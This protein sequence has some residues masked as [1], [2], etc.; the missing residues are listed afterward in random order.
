[1]TAKATKLTKQHIWL[2][3][4]SKM[5]VDLVEH[6]LSLDVEKAIANISELNPRLSTLKE[7]KQWFIQDD[8]QKKNPKYVLTNWLGVTIQPKRV[9]QDM[10]EGL[11]ET[12]REIDDDSSMQM[13]QSYGYA[14]NKLTIT[15]QMTSEI[16]SLNYG[17]ADSSGCALALQ[18]NQKDLK[19]YNYHEAQIEMLSTLSQKIFQELLNDNLLERA[20][21]IEWLLYQNGV[22][23]L[24]VTWSKNICQ[25]ALDSVSLKKNAQWFVTWSTN[26]KSQLNNYKCA[27]GW[28]N[29][30]QLLALDDIKVE[31][32]QYHD[33]LF[34]NCTELWTI[35]KKII[36]LKPAEASK[37][38]YIIDALSSEHVEYIYSTYSKTITV[39][40]ENDFIQFMYYLEFLILQ[41]F[42]KH[43]KYEPDILIYINNNLVNNQPLKKQFNNL[44]QVAYKLHYESLPEFTNNHIQL[45][46][47]AEDYLLNVK[48]IN[49]DLKSDAKKD[50]KSKIKLVTFKKKMLSEDLDLALCQLKIWAQYN[51]AKSVFEKAFMISDLKILVQAFQSKPVKIKEKKKQIP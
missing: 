21:L 19:L 7:I 42:E 43:I 6:T 10:L 30:F 4:W 34:L 32:R 1:M 22:E 8:K 51:R 11:F 26:L 15:I 20:R 14:I 12:I 36:D 33:Q 31:G 13:V 28:F 46:K 24:L 25:M 40:P 23:N 48:A 29:D 38:Q 16:R 45:S 17:S 44:L 9:S 27:G 2:T 5:R 47:E 39:I 37:F 18:F 50:K 35:P 49:A 41:L 3:T